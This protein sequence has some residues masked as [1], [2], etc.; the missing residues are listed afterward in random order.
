MRTPEEV[1]KEF[2]EWGISISQWARENDFSPAL[3]YQVL[4]GRNKGFRGESHRIAVALKLKP[5]HDTER[6]EFPYKRKKDM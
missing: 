5:G 3:V 1:R 4:A 6:A 2:D